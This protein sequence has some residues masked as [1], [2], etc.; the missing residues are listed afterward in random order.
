M[1]KSKFF[2]KENLEFSRDQI[3]VKHATN[4]EITF[5]KVGLDY[6][7]ISQNSQSICIYRDQLTSLGFALQ[8]IGGMIADEESQSVDTNRSVNIDLLIAGKLNEHQENPNIEF[9]PKTATVE[10]PLLNDI[11]SESEATDSEV[12]NNTLDSSYMDGGVAVSENKED[13]IDDSQIESDPSSLTTSDEIKSE[14]DQ[15]SSDAP[16]ESSSKSF[17]KKVGQKLGLI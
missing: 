17:A 8:E 15:E 16:N 12:E 2:E 11:E 13:I 14:N 9:E 7:V 3:V 4:P 5:K 6:V 1:S 10:E